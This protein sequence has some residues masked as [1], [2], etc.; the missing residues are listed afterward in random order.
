MLTK[1]LSKEINL[2]L[3]ITAEIVHYQG[4]DEIVRASASGMEVMT[5]KCSSGKLKDKH[6]E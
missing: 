4:G 2:K 6:K 3:G 5:A 1:F